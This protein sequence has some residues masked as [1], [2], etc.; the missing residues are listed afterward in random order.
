[1]GE[2][3]QKFQGFL[4]GKIAKWKKEKE[5]MENENAAHMISLQ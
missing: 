4:D 1:L 5:T 2:P 3:S